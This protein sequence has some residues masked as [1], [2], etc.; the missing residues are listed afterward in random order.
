[1]GLPVCACPDPH[2]P[3]RCTCA[4]SRQWVGHSHAGPSVLFAKSS[5][6]TTAGPSS[7]PLSQIPLTTFTS[8]P[9][10]ISQIS[11][12]SLFP[13]FSQHAC[14]AKVQIFKT[15][16]FHT[17]HTMI[18]HFH[19]IPSIPIPLLSPSASCCT[20]HTSNNSSPSKSQKCK[21]NAAGQGSS[22]CK[23][24]R[25]PAPIITAPTSSVC[26]VE[27]AIPVTSLLLDNDPPL[28]SPQ[29]P[30][31][32]VQSPIESSQPRSVLTQLPSTS[33]SSLRA[34]QKSKERSSIG[35]PTIYRMSRMYGT[36]I[37]VPY[38]GPVGVWSCDYRNRHTAGS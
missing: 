24:Q 6:L 5:C 10:Q 26:G 8:C 21:S 19:N 16:Y 36:V 17:Y 30:T 25:A 37:R 29:L 38:T 15:P 3:G 23:C 33:Y 9:S 31:I 28:P 32:T 34:N 13:Q 35:V 12:I 1:M 27:P 4:Q 22:G 2:G 7:I 11:C 20:Y 18:M 14:L